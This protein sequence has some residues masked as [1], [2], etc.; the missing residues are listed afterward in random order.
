MK[1]SRRMAIGTLIG[2]V[3]SKNEIKDSVERTI[4]DLRY[5]GEQIYTQKDVDYALS[6]VSPEELFKKEVAY[7]TQQLEHYTKIANGDF[8]GLWHEEQL[9][10]RQDG[11]KFRLNEHNIHSLKSVSAPVKTMMG[12]DYETENLKEKW[13]D[14]AK[15]VLKSLIMPKRS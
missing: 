3:A 15:Q 5:H 13:V 7:Y 10:E 8:S 6:T 14:E 2:G 4:K 9:E 11:L 12:H 1:L